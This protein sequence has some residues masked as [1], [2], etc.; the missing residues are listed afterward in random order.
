MQYY[1]AYY[2]NQ[3]RRC[4]FKNHVFGEEFSEAGIREK[5]LT[6]LMPLRARYFG[7]LILQDMNNNPDR[8]LF[9]TIYRTG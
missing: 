4:S 6:F 7:V 9:L 2:T 1:A 8:D 3:W 5:E